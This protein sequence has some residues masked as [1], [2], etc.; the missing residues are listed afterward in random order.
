MVVTGPTVIM[1]MLRAVRPSPRVGDSLRWE[2]IIID[3]IG[4]L[5]A[6][7]VYELIVANQTAATVIDVAKHF[8]STVLVGTFIGLTIGYG[9]G[10]LLKTHR[11]PEHTQNYAALAITCF[12]FAL[13]DTLRHESGLLAVTLMG[14]LLANMKGVNTRSI[15]G[16]KEDLT[17][18]LVSVLFIVLAARIEFAGFVAIGFSAVGLFL[19]MQLVAR[20]INVFVSFFKSD[21]SHQ[22]KALVAWVGPRGI[23]AAAVV[24]IFAIRMESLGYQGAELLVPLAFS[25]IIG[26]VVVQGF[27][28]RALAKWLGVAQ[29]DTDGIIIFGANKFSI[30]FS[31]ALDSI[32]I[33][34]LLCDTNWDKLRPAR[35]HGVPTYHGNPSSKDALRKIELDN[36]S[37]F[38]GLSDHYEANTAQL[39]RFREEFGERKV[40]ILPPHRSIGNQDKHAVDEEFAARE[41]FGEDLDSFHLGRHLAF[42]G[43]IKVT[44]LSKTFDR[45]K[46]LERAPNSIALCIFS[47]DGELVFLSSQDDF[48]HNEG[49]QLIYLAS[50]FQK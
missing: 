32:G 43:E 41:L 13:S 38:L 17:I 2:G 30:E 47:T 4:A 37:V 19:V 21:F 46:W 16:F 24:A 36:F 28:S 10:W 50:G 34:T 20:P 18:I 25:I 44:R 33:N 5:F 40:Y 27:T 39:N 26:T 22:E 42:N 29:P 35:L 31:R 14:I 48:P 1:P 7:L 12:T 9:L 23:V 15:L 49:D 6:V 11:I 45:T 8:G 3:P